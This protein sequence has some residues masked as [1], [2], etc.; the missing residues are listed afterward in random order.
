LATY[1]FVPL[2]FA[3]LSAS[4]VHAEF[5]AFVVEIES[6]EDS[7][8]K[9]QYKLKNAYGKPLGEVCNVSRGDAKVLN[10]LMRDDSLP[11]PINTYFMKGGIGFEEVFPISDDSPFPKDWLSQLWWATTLDSHLDK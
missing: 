1:W 9:F 10:I 7:S 6:E 11:G 8:G 4:D 2:P 3:P 5:M